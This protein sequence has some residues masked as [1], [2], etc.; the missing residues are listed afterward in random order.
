MA[1]ENYNFISWSSGTPITG[2]R[3]AQMSI[4]IEQIK[5][6]VDSAARG[7][8]AY[9]SI[10]AHFP[11]TTGWNTANIEQ[12]II[13]LRHE[14]L[15]NANNARDNR[16]SIGSN[17]WMKLTFNL[18]GIVIK[19]AG[20][21]DSRFEIRMYEGT[22]GAN[23]KTLLARWTVTPHT[24][25][26]INVASAAPNITNEALKIANTYPSVVGAGLYSHV[27]Y[28]YNSET[29]LSF[30]VTIERRAGASAA[31]VPS[32]YLQGGS[33]GYGSLIQFYAEDCG[34]I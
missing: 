3:L 27:T 4:N 16:V 25:S 19:N 29:N 22:D 10:G 2:E 9:S 21:E 30:F 8:L 6:A 28:T 23:S 5:E 18:P 13:F 17:R 15:F 1:Y 26:Y 7:I 14:T 34:A 12:D 33:G 31:N 11:S 20:S 24:Y 32:W